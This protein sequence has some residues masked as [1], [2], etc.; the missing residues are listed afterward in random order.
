MVLESTRLVCVLLVRR[1]WPK[2]CNISV[3]FRPSG[4][5]LAHF[6]SDRLGATVWVSHFGLLVWASMP[7]SSLSVWVS[8]GH[9]VL[10]HYIHVVAPDGLMF[11]VESAS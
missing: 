4:L 5:G 8:F 10:A 2:Y 3:P 9:E 6:L 11:E 1:Q 7:T